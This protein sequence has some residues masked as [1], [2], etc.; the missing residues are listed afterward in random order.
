M[1]FVP[2]IDGDAW[3]RGVGVAADRPDSPGAEDHD[4][5]SGDDAGSDDEDDGGIETFGDVALS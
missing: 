3:M 5:G 2:E 1:D 4:G